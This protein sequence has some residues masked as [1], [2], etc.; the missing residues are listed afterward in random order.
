LGNNPETGKEIKIGIGKF[1]PYLHY[2]E[3][4]TSIPKNY[5]PFDLDIKTALEII[6]K[7]QKK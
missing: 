4:F 6:I 7:K 3:K 2:D 5:S 1:G